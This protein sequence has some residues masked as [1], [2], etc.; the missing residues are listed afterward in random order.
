M[1]AQDVAAHATGSVAKKIA[2]NVKV[3]VRLY[4]YAKAVREVVSAVSVM[5]CVCAHLAKDAKAAGPVMGP[6][7][8]LHIQFGLINHGSCNQAG[9]TLSEVNWRD[10]SKTKQLA[11]RGARLQCRI[12]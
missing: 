8:I 6:P 12:T 3:T 5:G 11:T 2:T 7:Y 1:L 4:P 10:R 9:R